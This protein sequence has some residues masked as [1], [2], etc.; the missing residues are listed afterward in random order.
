MNGRGSVW[1]VA[2][3]LRSRF[4]AF[5]HPRVKARGSVLECA[6]PLALLSVASPAES[7]TGV[8]QSRTLSR[9]ADTEGARSRTGRAAPAGEEGFLGAA[10]GLNEGTV[11]ETREGEE[12]VGEFFFA[13]GTMG[14]GAATGG[15]VQEPKGI[16]RERAIAGGADF[17]LLEVGPIDTLG[18]VIWPV[19]DYKGVRDGEDVIPL[20]RQRRRRGIIIHRGIGQLFDRCGLGGRRRVLQRAFREPARELPH[21]PKGQKDAEDQA[22]EKK[23]GLRAHGGEGEER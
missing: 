23:E 14:D 8:E 10:H 4:D 12:E 3:G 18:G 9:H 1:K 11:V 13:T 2:E 22:Q 15:A 7:F 20:R 21:D 16:W 17:D 6:S 19:T 5:K